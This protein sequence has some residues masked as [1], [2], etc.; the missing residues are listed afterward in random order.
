MALRS[1]SSLPLTQLAR[2]DLSEAGQLISAASAAVEVEVPSVARKPPV[3]DV[4]DL[5]VG[6][7][8]D[9]NDEIHATIICAV[10]LT[11]AEDHLTALPNNTDLPRREPER[12]QDRI[13]GLRDQ[14]RTTMSRRVET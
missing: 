13:E 8:F 1:R 4:G 7:R 3:A 2:E 5:P 11:L 10:G 6:H 9:V 14:V 12:N